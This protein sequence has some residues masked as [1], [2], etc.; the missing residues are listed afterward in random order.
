MKKLLSVTAICLCVLLAGG[1][2]VAIEF[3]TNGDFDDGLTAWDTSPLGGGVS[4]VNVGGAY[5]NVALL[6]DPD[7]FGAEWLGQN[8][9]IDPV[10]VNPADPT[11][12]VS[13]DFL[14]AGVDNAFFLDDSASSDFFTLDVGPTLTQTTLLSVASS[15]PEFG[16]VVNFSGSVNAADLLDFDPNARIQFD[17]VELL[18]PS[19]FGG[20][21]R[22]DTFLYIDNVS[23]SGGPAGPP[24]GAVP[25]PGTMLLLGIGLIGLSAV[26]PRRR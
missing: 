12:T 15:D 7:S 3:I 10:L 11:V 9:Y 25:E 18:A 17:I 22:L 5:G 24:P 26:L 14:F 19:L 20:G 6:S 16:T 8:F 23:V 21:D 4:I 13:F 2:A 1:T